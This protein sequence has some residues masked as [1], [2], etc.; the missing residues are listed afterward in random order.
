MLTMRRNPLHLGRNVL[1]F[2]YFDVSE[3]QTQRLAEALYP[4]R[5]PWGQ[6]PS[7][8]SDL[9][10]RSLGAFLPQDPGRAALAVDQG[11]VLP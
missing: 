8:C 10:G 3:P 7:G 5:L 4:C 1:I 2:K 6:P 11:K 9:A